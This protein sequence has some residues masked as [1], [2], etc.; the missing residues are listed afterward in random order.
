VNVA[1]TVVRSSFWKNVETLRNICSPIFHLLR[2]MDS[3]VPSISKV[4]AGMLS[5][6]EH[7]K[8]CE[9]LPGMSREKLMAAVAKRWE[10]LHR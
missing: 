7:V 3:G 2:Q 10:Y 8:T 6:Q 5:L 4:Y 9:L 1:D